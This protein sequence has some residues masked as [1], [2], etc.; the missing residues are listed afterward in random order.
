M[1]RRQYWVQLGNL[2]CQP[3]TST[4]LTTAP[5]FHLDQFPCTRNA[6]M[7]QNAFSIVK[8]SQLYNV[9]PSISQINWSHRQKRSIY[10]SLQMFLHTNSHEIHFL[11]T[12]GSTFVQLVEVTQTLLIGSIFVE[13]REKAMYE[14]CTIECRMRGSH[15]TSLG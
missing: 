10:S 7:L 8:N 15:L 13:L 12:V 6:T 11:C 4:P 14:M 9:S 3:G 1:P 2:Q 5:H